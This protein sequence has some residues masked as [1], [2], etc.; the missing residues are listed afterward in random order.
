MEEF[1][2]YKITDYLEV[3]SERKPTPGGGSAAAVTAALG[4]S[5]IIMVANYSLGKSNSERIDN[6]IKIIIKKLE[7]IKAELAELI[8]LDAFAYMEVVRTRTLSGKEKNKAIQFAKKV[9]SRIC[10][11]SYEAIKLTPFL[12][13]NGSKYLISDLEI[14][15]ELLFAAYNSATVLRRQN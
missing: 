12:V 6:K 10:K 3:L 13:E 2:K 7:K 9:P 4:S 1:K 14:A 15:V 11:M 8:D 5:L